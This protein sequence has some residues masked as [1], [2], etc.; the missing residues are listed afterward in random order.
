M[1][2]VS[3]CGVVVDFSDPL[4]RF[5][6]RPKA[7]CLVCGVPMLRPDV[8]ET[9]KGTQL[10]KLSIDL[11]GR[12]YKVSPSSLLAP[13]VSLAWY[14]SDVSITSNA[15]ITNYCQ[16]RQYSELLPLSPVCQHRNFP[17]FFYGSIASTVVIARIACIGVSYVCAVGCSSFGPTVMYRCTVARPQISD[18]RSVYDLALGFDKSFG[19]V[20]QI[21]I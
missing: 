13:S 17:G 19:H 18:G 14:N 5:V 16:Y 20:R 8:R 1:S 4:R 11:N 2:E 7:F 6:K 15:T 21:T 10:A 12:T 3:R 9:L